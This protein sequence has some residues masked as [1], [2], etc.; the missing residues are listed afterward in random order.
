MEDVMYDPPAYLWAITIAGP[1]A[2]AAMVWVVLYGGAER[3]GLG[4]G[5]AALLAAAAAALFGGWLAGSAVIAS[6]GWYRTL[7]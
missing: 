3:A 1:V 4:H 6:Q 5:R 2:V 7:P